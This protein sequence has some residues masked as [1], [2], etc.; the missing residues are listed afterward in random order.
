MI[1]KGSLAIDGSLI[2]ESNG[3]KIVSHNVKCKEI[4]SGFMSPGAM[5]MGALSGCKILTFSKAMKFYNLN[6]SKLS[7]EVNA[8]VELLDNISDTPFKNQKYTEIKT[9]YTLKTDAKK[10]DIIK[11][12]ELSTKFCTVNIAVDKNIKQTFE[13]NIL[14]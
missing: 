6:F 4:D 12:I 14:S 1:C 13:I 7:V 10:E 11:A 8:N 2:F 3:Q 5:F 9:V